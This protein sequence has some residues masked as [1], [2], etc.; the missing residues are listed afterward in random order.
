MGEI[1]NGKNGLL[2]AF[3]GATK[4]EVSFMIGASSKP[5][6]CMVE[7]TG[8]MACPACYQTALKEG[9]EAINKHVAAHNARC[10]HVVHTVENWA[11]TIKAMDSGEVF[12]CEEA[13]YWYFLEVLPPI[14]QRGTEFGFAEGSEPVTKFWIKGGRYFGKRT[15]EDPRLMSER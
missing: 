5:D 1:I 9:A 2:C 13:V 6:W 15:K 8:K 3:C 4:T 14:Y 10:A 11:E 12:E 7:G